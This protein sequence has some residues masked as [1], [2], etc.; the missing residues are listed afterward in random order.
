MKKT[1][2]SDLSSAIHTVSMLDYSISLEQTMFEHLRQQFEMESNTMK[3][4]KYAERANKTDLQCWWK[5][6]GKYA[7]NKI[8]RKP[9]LV[10]VNRLIHT[11]FGMANIMRLISISYAKYQYIHDFSLLLCRLFDWSDMIVVCAF[12]SPTF[13]NGAQP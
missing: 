9:Y 10:Q 7:A 4:G 6:N 1:S 12:E 13:Q 3:I 11:F 2:G 5:K 8:N